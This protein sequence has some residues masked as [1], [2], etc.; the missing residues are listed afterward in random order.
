MSNKLLM[1][2][3]IVLLFDYNMEYIKTDQMIRTT[4]NHYRYF[5]LY[6]LTQPYIFFKIVMSIY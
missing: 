4:N 3:S 2:V 6:S 1:T 5:I